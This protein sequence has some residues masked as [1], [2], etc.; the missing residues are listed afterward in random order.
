MRKRFTTE[1]YTKSIFMYYKEKKRMAKTECVSIKLSP[2]E[3]E[4]VLRL[5]ADKDWTVS[6]YLYNLL[7]KELMKEDQ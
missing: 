7:I 3:K 5:A 4:K 2:E 6:K 1:T